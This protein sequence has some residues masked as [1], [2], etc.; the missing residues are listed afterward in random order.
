MVN[1][2]NLFFLGYLSI[3]LSACSAGGSS[4]SNNPPSGSYGY[5]QFTPT[6]L[7]MTMGTTAEVNI[8]L[9]DSTLSPALLIPLST[10]ADG[11]VSIPSECQLN[12]KPGD[13]Q[14]GNCTFTVQALK[15]GTTKI[16]AGWD[17]WPATRDITVT[18]N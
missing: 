6:S 8:A 4:S 2:C 10:S 14:W 3:I 1:K 18:V 7:N 16:I 11:I 17:K 9:V 5:I 15:A 12:S 13:G